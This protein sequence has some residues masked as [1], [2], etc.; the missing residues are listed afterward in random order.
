MTDYHPVR[1][2]PSRW[3]EPKRDERLGALLRDLLGEIPFGEVHWDA[4]AGRIGAVI[5]ASPTAPWWSYVERWQ[6]RAIPLAV[7]AGLVGALVLFHPWVAHSEG[8]PLTSAADLV[9]AV[10]AGTPSEDAATTFA[11]S[12]TTVADLSEEVIE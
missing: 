7:A 12:V 10:V 2:S 11:R 8:L 3:P 5:R 6:R 9:S 1:G 4:L